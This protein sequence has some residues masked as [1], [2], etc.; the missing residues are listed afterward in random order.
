MLYS[1]YSYSHASANAGDE[2]QSI[3]A[4]QYLPRVDYY[5]DKEETSKSAGQQPSSIIANG[6]Y[7]NSANA[8]P[9]P[10][11][12]TPLYT[13]VHI[14]EKYKH[15][16]LSDAVLAHLREHQPIGCRDK[17]TMLMLMAKGL[18]CYLSGCLTLTLQR[19]DVERGEAVYLVDLPD[20]VQIPESLQD[21]AIRRTHRNMPSNVE[22][23]F[24]RA[25]IHLAEYASARLV[26]TKRLHVA[27][28]CIAFGTPVIMFADNPLDYRLYP[29]S[30]A[31]RIYG[32]GEE[33]DWSPG[34]APLPPRAHGLASIVASW[35]R[36]RT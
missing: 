19:P 24:R 13:S 21:V 18:D 32:P 23:R 16:M 1:A 36:Y 10:P 7:V 31:L 27:L 15:N 29:A 3:A 4:M 22:D 34:P 8:L 30:E 25:R 6:W 11:N 12:L 5:V 26:V 9:L 2:I 17:G 33:C 20:W 28:P 35:V 14:A